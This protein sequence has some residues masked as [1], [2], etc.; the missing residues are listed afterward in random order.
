M[1]RDIVKEIKEEKE[2]RYSD[3]KNSISLSD[4]L[5]NKI[6][7]DIITNGICTISL[8]EEIPE[9]TEEYEYE[10]YIESTLMWPCTPIRKLTKGTRKRVIN[11]GHYIAKRIFEDMGLFVYRL[12]SS[13]ELT[14]GLPIKEPKLFTDPRKP[15]D[16]GKRS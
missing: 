12:T 16:L 1:T 7:E 9:L 15:L 14:L 5:L 8:L 3:L 4:K 6:K 11:N 2:K 10:F 13:T